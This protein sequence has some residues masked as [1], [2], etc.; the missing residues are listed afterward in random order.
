MYFRTTSGNHEAASSG[1][2]KET[3]GS[4]YSASWS[5][6]RDLDMFSMHN[7]Y[8]T[9]VVDMFYLWK[10]EGQLLNDR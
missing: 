2:T 6:N 8:G 10:G 1:R 4:Y 5:A 9:E 7:D 3:S